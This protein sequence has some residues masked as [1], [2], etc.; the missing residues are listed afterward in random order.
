[1]SK[2][3]ADGCDIFCASI[4]EWLAK[5]GK[6]FHPDA[7]PVD[8][9][10]FVQ[11]VDAAKLLSALFSD[12]SQTTLSFDKVRHS[13]E[14]TNWLLTNKPTE[15]AELMDY[16]VGLLNVNPPDFLQESVAAARQ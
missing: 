8:D 16:V 7:L 13:V 4:D 10:N 14:L 5:K 6:D 9:C 12:L 2:H 1:M 3:A 15:L 11:K